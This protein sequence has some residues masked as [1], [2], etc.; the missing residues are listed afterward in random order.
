MSPT[1]EQLEIAPLPHPAGAERLYAVIDAVEEHINQSILLLASGDPGSALDF[2]EWLDGKGLPG[3]EDLDK[4]A[5]KSGMIDKYTA[6]E[7]DMTHLTAELDQKNKDIKNSAVDTFHTSN[8]TYRE[9]TTIVERLRTKLED[10]PAPTK[11]VDG[12]Y[13][14]PVGVEFDLLRALLNAADQVHAEV[15]GAANAIDAQA[16]RIDGSVP[17]VPQGYDYNNGGIPAAA[18]A[19]QP[20]R[21][22]KASYRI[23]DPEDPVGKTLSVAGGELGTRETDAAFAGKPYNN[24]SAWCAAFTSWVW[25]EA[26]YDVT[27]TDFDYVPDVWNDAEV[28]G[29][30]RNNTAEAQPGDL[31]VF[32]W[33]GDG[34]PDHIGIVEAVNG[35]KIHT[36]EGNSSD[37]VARRN[38]GINSG[39]VVGVI[40]PPP[41]RSE[42]RM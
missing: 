29:L 25:N 22:S 23:T 24:G 3:G 13:R 2:T 11:G 4:P 21:A 17:T 30:R 1:V 28:L 39:E 34:T 7:Q 41:T 35:G 38:Y 8:T 37:Q 19:Y 9:I 32:D 36:I 33:E 42:V 20:P 15:E 31:I 5:D 40:K 6:R 26:G 12:V 10:T 16:R 27:W 14:L 18:N